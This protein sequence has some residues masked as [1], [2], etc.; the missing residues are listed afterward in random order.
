MS[1]PGDSSQAL[2]RILWNET[3]DDEEEYDV[4][5][6]DLDARLYEAGDMRL[7]GELVAA[8]AHTMVPAN[9]PQPPLADTG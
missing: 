7:R 3:E 1:G 8:A 6:E 4:L 2:N 5:R 9:A